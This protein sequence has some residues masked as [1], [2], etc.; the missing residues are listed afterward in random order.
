MTTASDPAVQAVTALADERD[1]ALD[2]LDGFCERF[3]WVK[4]HP[5]FHAEVREFLTAHAR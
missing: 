3:Y 4:D 1:K 5:D 2:L